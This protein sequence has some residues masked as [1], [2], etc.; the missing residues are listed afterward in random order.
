MNTQA[1]QEI[2]NEISSAA[3]A[4]GGGSVAAIAGANGAALLAMVCRLTIG[5]KKYEAVAGEMEKAL[6]QADLLQN[7]LASLVETDT[8]AFEQVMAAMKLPKETPEQIEK[9]RTEIQKATHY[10]TQVP[11]ETM[12]ACMEGMELAQP[13]VQMGNTNALSDG[14]VAVLMLEAGMQGA[15]LNVM[16]N[17]QGIEDEEFKASCIKETSAIL[18]K[19]AERKKQILEDVNSRL[20]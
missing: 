14:G 2:L 13:V 6:T 17:L 16:I 9:R 1:L 12:R 3:P 11:L 7:R 8:K 4:P 19:A 5:K 20:K 15:N 18:E 10:A